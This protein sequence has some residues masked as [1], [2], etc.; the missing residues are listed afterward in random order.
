MKHGHGK[1]K[2]KQADELGNAKCNSYEGMYEQDK[3]HGYGVFEWESG[4]RYEGNYCEDE[5]HGYGIMK[6]TD[7]SQYMGVWDRGI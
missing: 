7:E 5:R 3:K 6:W 2:K 1:W 4:N